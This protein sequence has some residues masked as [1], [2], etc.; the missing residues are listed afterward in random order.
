M[1]QGRS[2]KGSGRNGGSWKIGSLSCRK[3]DVVAEMFFLRLLATFDATFDAKFDAT[4][5][6]RFAKLLQSFV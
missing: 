4:F 5:D 6:A 1:P 2:W 3:P